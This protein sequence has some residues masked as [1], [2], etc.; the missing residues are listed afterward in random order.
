MAELEQVVE[1]LIEVNEFQNLQIDTGTTENER[2]LLVLESMHLQLQSLTETLV[3]QF[4]T[5]SNSILSADPSATLQRFVEANVDATNNV[6]ESVDGVANQL[7]LF[8]DDRDRSRLLGSREEDEEGSTDKTNRNQSAAQKKGF[9]ASNW[10]K[11][12]KDGEQFRMFGGIAATI[13]EAIQTIAALSYVAGQLPAALRKMGTAIKRLGGALLRKIPFIT[14]IANVALNLDEILAEDSVYNMFSA[15]LEK[16]MEG[17]LWP[18]TGVLELIMKLSAK[19]AGGLGLTELE[20]EL[21]NFDGNKAAK[22]LAAAGRSLF[23]GVVDAVIGA[24]SGVGAAILE[25]FGFE[26]LAA[27]LRGV[28]KEKSD[29]AMAATDVEFR[30]S[31]AAQTRVAEELEASGQASRTVTQEQKDASEPALRSAI[32]KG[33]YFPG[34]DGFFGVNAHITDKITGASADELKAILSD[35][36]LPELQRLQVEKLLIEKGGTVNVLPVNPME[37]SMATA[38]TAFEREVAEAPN[39]EVNAANNDLAEAETRVQ[40]AQRAYDATEEGSRSRARALTEL[41]IATSAR[42]ARAEDLQVA[43]ERRRLDGNAPSSPTTVADTTSLPSSPLIFNTAPRYEVPSV[44]AA[45]NFQ[46]YTEN[47]MTEQNRLDNSRSDVEG[48]SNNTAVISAPSSSSVTTYTTVQGGGTPV[49]SN[50][51]DGVNGNY[52]VRQR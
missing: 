26:E 48:S 2:M 47:M 20:E 12:L 49:S 29:A 25:F 46:S 35:Q 39:R 45:N 16:F 37:R 34:S 1:K 8:D 7:S 4:T 38:Q 14:A 19:V 17:F 18:F 32:D 52:K 21:N 15:S 40:E 36:K 33:M 31:A 24:L 10:D 27:K 23:D 44:S 9:F 5:L 22:D 42:N 51:M 11:G 43:E 28:E 50:T 6:A 41:N 3:R 30:T 13:A